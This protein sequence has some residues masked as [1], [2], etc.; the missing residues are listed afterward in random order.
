MPRLADD[1]IDTLLSAFG[2]VEIVGSRWCGKTW[3]AMTHGESIVHID[4]PQTKAIAEADPLIILEGERPHVVDEWQ[5]VPRIWDAVRRSID[6]EGEK[7][8]YLLT[9]SSTLKKD[10]VTHSGAGRIA[11]IH[12]RP[13]SLYESGESSGDISLSALF[14]GEFK[15]KAVT[16]DLRDIAK[17][18]CRGGW[19]GA[20]SLSDE[21]Y[22]E[23]ATQYL[24][25]IL[26]VNIPQEGK[27]ESIARK[28]LASLARNLG[29]SLTYKTIAADMR[30]G[31]DKDDNDD[32]YTRYLI[33]SY[34]ELLKGQY[35]IEDLRGWDAPIKS[36]SRLRTKPKRYFVDPSLSAA[37]LS[38]TP[39]RLIGNMQLFGNLFEELCIR[40]LRVYAS[41]MKSALPEP[42]YH[43]HDADGL[44]VDAI[45]E[46]RD[47]RYG[48]IEIKLSEDGVEK[49]IN[50][51][52]RFKKKILANKAAKNSPPSFM[53][54]IVGNTDFQRV[55]SIEDDVIYIIPITA[56]KP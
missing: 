20:L 10:A 52:R 3:T 2:A 54:V 8:L 24:D 39:E 9:G 30:N 36:K 15:T 5:E 17:Y 4:D 38:V 31:E 48:A 43:Y 53:A 51:L 6:S 49:G 45:I 11:K 29:Q 41:S 14:E 12:M 1:R 56:L 50:S 7:G 35:F 34:L 22:M 13:M 37:T 33:E 27:K 23:I 21:L 18:I 26:S 28:L 42:L 46:Q 47:G 55:V 40:D 25:T 32:E 44:E 16:T 19:P